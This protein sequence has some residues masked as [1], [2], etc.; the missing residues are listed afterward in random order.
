MNCTNMTWCKPRVSD[1]GPD[2][3]SS[4]RGQ[5]SSRARWTDCAD[6]GDLQRQ[7]KFSRPIR[8]RRHCLI[9]LKN[10]ST[11]LCAIQASKSA[12]F[13]FVSAE[14]WPTRHT[15]RQ[16]RGQLSR[17]RQTGGYPNLATRL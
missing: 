1:A 9:L 3:K 6:G 11:R 16:T 4:E 13:D 17:L 15:L 8:I 10:R 2:Q 5:R 14:C 12:L 7:N